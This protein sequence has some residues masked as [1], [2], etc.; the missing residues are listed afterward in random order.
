MPAFSLAVGKVDEFFVGKGAGAAP[1]VRMP[2]GVKESLQTS[3]RPENTNGIASY[4][5]ME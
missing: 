1:G 2:P 3:E 4:H 5:G